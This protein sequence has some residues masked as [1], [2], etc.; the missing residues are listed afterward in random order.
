MTRI[1]RLKRLAARLTAAELA[2]LDADVSAA[3]VKIARNSDAAGPFSHP[4]FSVYV[5]SNT[6][7]G[8][9]KL[10][11]EITGVSLAEAKLAVEQ[12]FPQWVVRS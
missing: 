5:A 1:D 11:R 4:G 12:R 6:K 8:A 3:L 7:I 9:I 2:T 10:Y